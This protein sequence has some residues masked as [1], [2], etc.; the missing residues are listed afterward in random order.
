ML[1]RP[2]DSPDP[3]TQGLQREVRIRPIVVGV[4]RPRTDGDSVNVLFFFKRSTQCILAINHL[5]L[6]QLNARNT[7]NTH[8]YDKLS[9][10]C[11]GVRYT[12]FRETFALLTQN[13][14]AFCNEDG[15]TNTETCRRQLVINIQVGARNVVALIVHIRHFYCYKS[16]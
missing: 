2:S 16:I 11:C 8:I 7:L 9:R 12:I 15:V 10:T 1:D 14:Y 13:L 6:L 5:F 3:S 4:K